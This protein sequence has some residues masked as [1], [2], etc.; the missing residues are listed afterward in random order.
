M[1]TVLSLWSG[2][3][4]IANTNLVFAVH[5]ACSNPNIT[6]CPWQAPSS[7]RPM[8]LTTCDRTHM[9][10]NSCK[11]AQCG[12]RGQ[13]N[14][15]TNSKTLHIGSATTHQASGCMV[16]CTTSVIGPLCNLGSRLLTWLP[17]LPGE[18]LFACPN[19]P[20]PYMLPGSLL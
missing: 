3:Y 2:C 16:R 18:R 15:I 17:I 20:C 4:C 11:L 10:T 13:Q 14:S 7:C 8:A 12:R 9:H 19:S 6:H 1:H 5:H